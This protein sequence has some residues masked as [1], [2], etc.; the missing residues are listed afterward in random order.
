MEIT[1]IVVVHGG[2]GDVPEA[3]RPLH[4]E[5][6]R[7][8]A[9][10]G[11][12]VLLEGGSALDAAI[13][14]VARMEDDPLFNAGTGASLNE[15]GELE[16]DASVMEGTTLRGGGVCGLPPFQNPV[17]I[18]RAVMDEG[19]HVLY[20]AEGARAFAERMG[21]SPRTVDEMITEHARER[22]ARF[23]EGKVSEGWAGNTV[24]AVACDAAGRVA[25][26]TSTGGT[27]GKA[28]GRVGDTPILG[29]GTYADDLGGAVSATGIGET[30]L[31][32]CLARA[33]VDRMSA[34]ETAEEAAD[35]AMRVFGSR[36]GGSGG[37]V[38]VDRFGRP[39]ARFNT[40][41]MSHAIARP[42]GVTG[43]S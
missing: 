18:A 14:A 43:A 22:L 1:P 17:K 13:A 8:A 9:R 12:D 39:A 33:V 6:V 34:G 7:S 5:G 30:I 11:L 36:F 40:A 10:C 21:F 26:A 23:L 32:A 4:V 3:R 19:R 20:A 35:A 27:V 15:R 42:D 37:I 2:A 41:T 29:A 16:L 28:F 31:R 25:A 24:G 38:V